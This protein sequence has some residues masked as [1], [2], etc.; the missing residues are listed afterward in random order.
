[1][2]AV[3]KATWIAHIA[4]YANPCIFINYQAR[5]P[6]R[7][8]KGMFNSTVMFS[9]KV[10]GVMVLPNTEDEL[11]LG[12][13]HILLLL[14]DMGTHHHHHHHTSLMVGIHHHHLHHDTVHTGAKKTN[15]GWVWS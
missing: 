13:N 9:E 5:K 2:V 3:A 1:M 6:S 4:S 7:K 11:V 10:D 14:E 12:G 15:L 8:P